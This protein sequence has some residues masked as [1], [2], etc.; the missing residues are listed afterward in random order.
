MNHPT[1]ANHAQSGQS[2]ALTPSKTEGLK[3]KN[4][5]DFTQWDLNGLMKFCELMLIDMNLKEDI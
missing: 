4:K 1:G 2:E 5:I 3:Q